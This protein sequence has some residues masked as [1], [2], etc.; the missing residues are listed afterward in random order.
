MRKG[1]NVKPIVAIVAQG[2]MASALAARLTQ[3]G[4]EV[5]TTISGRS[6]ASR[7]RAT[8]AGMKPVDMRQLLEA[9][10]LLSVLPPSA[11]LGFAQGLAPE[12][13]ATARKPLY[14]DC[15]AVSPESARAIAKVITTT[16]TE[17]VDAGIIG[18][19][20][21]EGYAGPKIYASGNQAPRLAQLR[22][23]GIDIRILS[24][25]IGAAS[26]LK[27]AYAG[28]TK[29]LTAVATVMILAAARAGLSEAL[30]QELSESE[31]LLRDALSRRIPDMLP[32]AYRW[33][34]EMHQISNFALPDLAG[35]AIYDGAAK[36]YERMAIDYAGAKHE[37]SA[38][39]QFFGV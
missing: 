1:W 25:D 30:E 31:P 9:D 35:A 10:I 21:R 29:G 13:R 23:F 12:L 20:P 2:A 6:E 38:L 26:G 14:V 33:I 39:T 5:R 3:H 11:A 34:D 7:A 19:P 28:I 8:A 22:S 32:K 4:I 27:M 37:A 15:N 17:F 36:L 16:G 18:L 24:G